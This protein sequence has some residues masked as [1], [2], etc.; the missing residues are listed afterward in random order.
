MADPR[1]KEKGLEAGAN[2][3]MQK[4]FDPNQLIGLIR[5]ALAIKA[6]R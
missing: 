3:A 5:K 6:K 1:L 2:L 4:P